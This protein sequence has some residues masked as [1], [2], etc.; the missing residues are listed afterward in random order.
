MSGSQWREESALYDSLPGPN[1]APMLGEAGAGGST[2][3]QGIG[4]VAGWLAWPDNV[5]ELT[6]TGLEIF[7]LTSHNNNL[8]GLASFVLSCTTAILTSK[9]SQI[10]YPGLASGYR[11]T[12]FS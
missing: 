6:D 5:S 3:S 9:M 1:V 10:C 4:I 12:A 11:G 8:P 7:S 2:L